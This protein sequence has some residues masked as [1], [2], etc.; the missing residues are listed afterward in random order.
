MESARP[1]LLTLLDPCEVSN[2][3]INIFKIVKGDISK[4]DYKNK[5]FLSKKR[6]QDCFIQSNFFIYPFG[7]INILTH[8]GQ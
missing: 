6:A 2:L 3:I 1:H 5:Q 8:K 7:K 4:K